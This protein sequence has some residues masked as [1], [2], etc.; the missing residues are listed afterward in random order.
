MNN[1][2]GLVSK[3]IYLMI[4]VSW[5]MNWNRY[6]SLDGIKLYIFVHRNCKPQSKY[7]AI[8]LAVKNDVSLPL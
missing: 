7:N 8:Y 3:P 2:T 1:A 4:E 6:F 5:L